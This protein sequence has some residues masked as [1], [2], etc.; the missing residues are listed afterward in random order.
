MPGN[1]SNQAEALAA[2]GLKVRSGSTTLTSASMTVI[3]GLATVTAVIA[4]LESAPVLTCSDATAQLGDQAGTPAAG[5]ILLKGW[6][7]TGTGDATPIPAT[8]FA[9]KKVNWLAIGT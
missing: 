9:S 8:G 2:A 1:V 6:M 5:S 7:P 3:T 4:S